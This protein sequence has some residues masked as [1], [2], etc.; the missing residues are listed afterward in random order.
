MSTLSLFGRVALLAVF[1]AAICGCI[2]TGPTLPPV[3]LKV[4]TRVITEEERRAETAPAPAAPAVGIEQHE[5]KFVVVVN[6]AKSKEY[7]RIGKPGQGDGWDIVIPPPL[8]DGEISYSPNRK[9]VAYIAKRGEKWLAVVDGKEEKEYDDVSYLQFSPDSKGVAYCAVRNGKGFVVVNGKET[10]TGM[11]KGLE[12]SPDS[13]RIAYVA[14]ENRKEAVVLDGIKG[15]GYD[16]VDFRYHP[17]DEKL[18]FSPDSKRLAYMAVS[19]KKMFMVIDGVESDEY[20]S[21]GNGLA[22]S[23]DSKRVAYVAIRDKKMMV[24][25]DGTEGPKYDGILG[26]YFSQDSKKIMYAAIR[27]RKWYIVIDGVE[28]RQFP[29]D[30]K[31][32]S[33]PKFVFSPN[34]QRYACVAQ[35]KGKKQ[36]VIVDGVKSVEYDGV[37]NGDIGVAWSPDSRHVAYWALRDRKWRIVVD[38]TESEFEGVNPISGVWFESPTRIKARAFK[39]GVGEIYMDIEVDES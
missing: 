28:V 34:A 5:K 33:W 3:Q 20:D 38:G 16:Y 15:K 4:T 35:A 26:V 12:F 31:A 6:G 37:C 24:V 2:G 27:G 11:V 25:V 32:S 7:D 10:E 21:I 23:P 22:F 19:G 39:E 9:R 36:M 30:V 17:G 13:K 18:V 14:L 29:Y 1:L 8:Y